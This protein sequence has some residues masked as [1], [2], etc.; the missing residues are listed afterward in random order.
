MEHKE[1]KEQDSKFKF[2]SIDNY[3]KYKWSKYSQLKGRHHH[4]GFKNTTVRTFLV[5]QWIGIH[6]LMQGTCVQFLV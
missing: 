5:V 6:L 4:I 2:N 1:N 3:I